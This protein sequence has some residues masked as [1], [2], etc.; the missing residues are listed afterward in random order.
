MTPHTQ[1]VRLLWSAVRAAPPSPQSNL[2]CVTGL[3]ARTGVSAGSA[4]K[5]KTILIIGKIRVVISA[6]G[7]IAILSIGAII[8]KASP[9]VLSG[10]RPASDPDTICSRKTIL[11]RWTCHGP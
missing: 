11:Q 5:C 10:I 3:S 8:G 9:N 2:L 6:R 7:W 1:D 4:K